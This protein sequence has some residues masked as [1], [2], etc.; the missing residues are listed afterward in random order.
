MTPPWP[1]QNIAILTNGYCG[2]TCAL[3]SRL[4]QEDFEVRQVAVGGYADQPMAFSEFAG[5]QVYQHSSLVSAAFRVEALN[6]S[7]VPQSFKSNAALSFTVREA[8][9]KTKPN[10]PLEFDYTPATFR[11]DLTKEN[12]FKPNVI[13]AQTGL[14][15]GWEDDKKP[16]L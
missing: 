13:W 8:Y 14:L 9:S 11:I 12:L 1:A 10:V 6:E 4:L 3:T 5:G 2:S 16:K 7:Y 15:M